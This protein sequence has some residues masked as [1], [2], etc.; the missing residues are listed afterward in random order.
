VLVLLSVCFSCTILAFAGSLG[1]E[2][3]VGE[4]NPVPNDPLLLAWRFP[5]D[6][7]DGGGDAVQVRLS[8]NQAQIDWG[9]SAALDWSCKNAD[10]CELT[11]DVG[12]L[13][14]DGSGTLHVSPTQT[15]RYT[16]TGRGSGSTAWAS[17]T[18][19]VINIPPSIAIIQP[20]DGASLTL[21]AADGVPVEI[22][23]S[24]DVGI[25]TGSFSASINDEEITD[26]FTVTETGATCLLSM[27]LPAG[28]NTFSATIGDVEDLT[29]TATSRFTVTYRPPTVS[30]GADPQTV[31]F[32]ESTTLSWRAT[33]AD[34]VTIEPMIGE[35]EPEDSISMT[36]YEKTLYTITATGPGGT[37]TD[38]VEV[39]VTDIPPPG[40]YYEYDAL[41]RIKRIIRMPAQ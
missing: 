40:I 33:D 16:L 18:I 29:R 6:W 9:E 19:T 41:G 37:A 31:S 22:E 21:G 12:A 25:D 13:D 34:T 8:T 15:T 23:Y 38:S 24:D 20:A 11:P 2:D 7:W 17:V 5:P 36:P 3:L 27:R 30:L 39:A 10:T 14:P 32:G 4:E 35:V 1:A 28:S 26:L